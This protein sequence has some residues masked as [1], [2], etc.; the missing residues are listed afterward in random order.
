MEEYQYKC[1]DP[2]GNTPDIELI[3]PATRL[4]DLNNKTVYFIDILKRN[5]DVI[6]HT[7]IKQLKTHYP[8]SRYVYYPKTCAYG[9][10][11]SEMWWNEITANADAAFVAVGD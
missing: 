10:P 3:P 1:M 6:I 8:D 9:K 7:M 11:E 5:S 4:H 2:R